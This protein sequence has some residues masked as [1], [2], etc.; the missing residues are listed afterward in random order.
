MF[1]ATKARD[2]VFEMTPQVKGNQKTQIIVE[3]DTQVLLNH[4]AETV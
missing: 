3:E 4:I 2:R 1:Q